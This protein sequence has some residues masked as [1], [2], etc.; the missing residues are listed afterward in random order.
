MA[1][2]KSTVLNAGIGKTDTVARHRRQT[3]RLL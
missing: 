1:E 3:S 2:E